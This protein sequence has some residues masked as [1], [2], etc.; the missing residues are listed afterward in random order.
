MIAGP[1]F[2]AEDTDT[3]RLLAVAEWTKDLLERGH[4][5]ETELAWLL[6][7]QY[8]QKTAL[9]KE[10][11]VTSLGFLN[12]FRENNEGLGNFGLLDE[13]QFCGDPDACTA[14]ELS[15]KVER[16]LSQR[17]YLQRWSDY[18]RCLQDAK[19]LNLDGITTL[20]S[21]KSIEIEDCAALYQYSLY[22][23]MAREVVKR[24]PRLASFNR[25]QHDNTIKRFAKLDAEYL[26]LSSKKIAHTISR[27]Q[28]PR[29]V[30]TGP[31][32]DHTEMA[33]LLRETQKQRRHIPIRQ[34]V[35]RAGV[36]LQTLKPCFMMSP[37][38]VAQY[39]EPGYLSF[40]IVVMDEASQIRPEDALGA[41]FRAKQMAIVGDPNQLPPTSFF[42]R[43]EVEQ[44]DGEQTAIEETQ[45]VLDICLTTFPK[46][47][48]IWHYRSDDPSLIAFSN[49]HFYDNELI[50]FPSSKK[51][52][53]GV[54]CHYIKDA[55]Y[56]NSKNKGEAEAVVVAVAEHFRTRPALSLGVAAMN[57]QQAELIEDI[58]DRAMK[59][60]HW[61]EQQ[62]KATEEGREPFFIKNLENVQ[63]DE[64]DVIFIS[65]T[66]GPDEDTGRVFQRFGPIGGD[67]G[68]RRM[69]VLFTRA[70]KRVEVFTSMTAAD[71]IP[72][73][74]TARGV[75]AL[76]AYIEYATTGRLADYGDI[77]SERPPDSDFEISVANILHSY[78]YRTAAQVGV[79]GFFI[80]L[81][82]KHPERPEFLLGIECDGASYHSAKNVR[83]RDKLRQEILERK[84]WQI[85][86]IWSTDWYKNREVEIKRLLDTVRLILEK[87]SSTV[88]VKEPCAEIHV[89]FKTPEQ[90]AISISKTESQA[91]EDQKTLE[92]QLLAFKRKKILPLFPDES[93]GILRKEML[94]LFVKK[95]PVAKEEF[96]T[97]IPMALRQKTNAMQLQFLDEIFEIIEVYTI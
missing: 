32:R 35:K 15:T 27:N 89:P 56:K 72:A 40:D 86:R 90:P 33:L 5:S 91:D 68:W 74:S 42:D 62:I 76:K 10:I 94:D 17:H 7:A 52:S 78:G 64:R 47:R 16:S 97:A 1:Y 28:P 79:A 81:A 96:F 9:F 43:V 45:S 23:S 46:K 80:D 13:R 77:N 65:T 36:A 53:C 67:M 44:S 48:L 63:G 20:I 83:D 24:E 2:K 84:G 31:V 55:R 60:N 18:C 3:K 39:L 19:E 93:N 49:K 4:F 29:G 70:K 95:K 58:M 71:I 8:E 25:I 50:V 30:Q 34:L 75:H 85:Y 57:R 37:L 66:Y 92:D 88:R 69:N 73:Q 21:G 14:D 22:D 59:A 54:F 6:D 61:L 82:V 41:I 51:D 38:S 87:D 26:S 11:I 12:R